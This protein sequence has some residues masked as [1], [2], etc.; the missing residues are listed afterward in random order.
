V[1]LRDEHAEQAA[2]FSWAEFARDRHPELA[3]LFAIPNGGH[4]H[5]A[6][7]A[8]MKAEGVK[9][10]VPDICLP[11]PR[12]PWHGLYIELKTDAG[13]VSREQRRWIGL[14]TL[15]GYRAEVCRG[16]QQARQLIENYLS[17]RTLPAGQVS[18]PSPTSAQEVPWTHPPA[19]N[20]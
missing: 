20:A 19:I 6:V 11:V 3:L 17:G 13:R 15:Q 7:A 10:G 18:K 2:L 9:R 1:K 14:L 12:G 8:R 16:W 5:R 4:R